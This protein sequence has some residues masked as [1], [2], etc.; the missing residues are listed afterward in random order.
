MPQEHQYIFT[1]QLLN[2]LLQLLNQ[3]QLF[4]QLIRPLARY[5]GNQEA[6]VL[7]E[8]LEELVPRLRTLVSLH[9]DLVVDVPLVLPFT[10]S[11]LKPLFPIPLSLHPHFIHNLFHTPLAK[12]LQSVLPGQHSLPIGN[13]APQPDHSPKT[14]SPSRSIIPETLSIT[15]SSSFRFILSS[16]F[17]LPSN[18]LSNSLS[19]TSFSIHIGPKITVMVFE[20]YSLF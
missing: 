9:H 1:V 11:F 7:L 13:I 17:I 20:I 15:S 16:L 3:L 4:H 10:Y 6:H 2:F 19:N 14:S 8:E 5:L 18:S 12:D